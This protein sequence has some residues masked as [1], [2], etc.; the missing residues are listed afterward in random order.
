[1]KDLF[2]RELNYVRISVTDRC[3][4]RCCYCM[5]RE[6]V[7][8]IPH[9]RIMS[10]EDIFFLVG[11]LWK[12]GV[13]KVRFTG[14]EPL[15]RKGMIPFLEKVR[16]SFPELRV[17]LTTNGS[18]LV[19]D[20][21]CLALMRLSGINVSLDTLEAEKFSAMTRGASLRNVLDGIEALLSAGAENVKM[22][23]VL[24]RGFND[25]EVG[26]L[27]DYARGKGIVLRFIEFMP[28]DQS[29]WSQKSFVPFQEVLTALPD[30]SDWR[31]ERTEAERET[32][33]GPARYYVHDGTGQRV[34]VISAVSQHFCM[35]CNRL[36]V[37]SVGEVRSCLFSNVQ[38]SIREALRARDEAAV[39]EKFFEAAALKPEVGMTLNRDEQRQMFKIGG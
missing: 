4:Y 37:T 15:V 18:T 8:W 39:R 33:S 36:R 3:N 23:A 12:L 29:V 5:P 22:N 30:A 21:S 27:L 6:G 34:G 14:G 10:Y 7:E 32:L 35:S 26:F 19:K 2:G 20:A 25:G 1:M 16:A 38:V 31:E 11:V 9:G 24:I 17:A 13:K 28:L